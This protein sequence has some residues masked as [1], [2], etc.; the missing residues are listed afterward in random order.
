MSELSAQTSTIKVG[1]K[2]AFEAFPK[3]FVFADGIIATQEGLD[4]A[5]EKQ[6]P[7]SEPMEIPVEALADAEEL[8]KTA[9]M[10]QEEKNK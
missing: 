5:A 3:V 6:E 7:A 9:K 2:L 1:D 8:Y 4:K 10:Y